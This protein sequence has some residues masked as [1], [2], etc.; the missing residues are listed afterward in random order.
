LNIIIALAIK[1]RVK[2]QKAM[3]NKTPG[4]T[5]N[6]ATILWHDYENQPEIMR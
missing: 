1:H 5:I 4:N 2:Q 3:N 6:Q